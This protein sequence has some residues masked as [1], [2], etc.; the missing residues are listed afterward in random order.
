MKKNKVVVFLSV[1]LVL[2]SLNANAT[3]IL[4]PGDADWTTDTN[5]QLS[6]SDI[7]TI[8][9]I[10]GLSNY[11][12][13][14][15]GGSEDFPFASVYDTTFSN[16][17]SDPADF[18]IEYVTGTAID[19]PECILIVKD[20]NQKPAQYLF[21]IGTW[22][23]TEDIQGTGFWPNQGAISN[24]AIYGGEDGSTPPADIPEP[25]MMALFGIGLMGMGLSAIRR[26][27]K[28]S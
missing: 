21:D 11:Y 2:V 26:K 28:I 8:T 4:T 18:L 7:E 23:G 15:V 22:D 17:P 12:K 1:I 27:R 9:G 13:D 24:V 5:S 16:S 6:L 25:G 19:C 14:N 10:S 20:G 3:L